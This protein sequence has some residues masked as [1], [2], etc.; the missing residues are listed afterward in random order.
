MANAALRHGSFLRLKETSLRRLLR[1]SGYSSAMLA[2][3]SQRAYPKYGIATAIVLALFIGGPAVLSALDPGG[4]GVPTDAAEVIDHATSIT[5][6][7]PADW[8]Q[9]NSQGSIILKKGTVAIQLQLTPFTGTPAEMYETVGNSLEQTTKVVSMGD[10]SPTTVNG[11]PA[12]QGQAHLIIDGAHTNAFIVVAADGTNAIVAEMYG[13]LT[14][15]QNLKGE[16]EQ[17]LSTVK[18]AGLEGGQ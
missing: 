13:P 9:E 2:T 4:S 16:F 5:Y 6:T 15:T 1:A 3:S 10:P 8:H 18:I 12:V 17:V 11:M 14:D 7:A